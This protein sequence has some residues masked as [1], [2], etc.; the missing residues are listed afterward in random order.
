MNTGI[1]VLP[2]CCVESNGSSFIVKSTFFSEWIHDWG[3][4]MGS[5]LAEYKSTHF[6]S[7]AYMRQWIGSALVRIMVCRLFGA[8][9]LSKPI[10]GYTGPLRINVSENQNTFLSFT[11]MHLKIASATWRP[12]CPAGAEF[13][14]LH[15][16]RFIVVGYQSILP[17]P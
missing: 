16:V 13:R 9:P 5:I 15:A 3:R 12:F 6:P 11:K 8:K 7:A 10:L 2:V 17:Y 14:N 4:Y 1:R